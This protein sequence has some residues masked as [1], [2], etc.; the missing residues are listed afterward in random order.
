MAYLEE[1]QEA[2]G[3]T[4]INQHGQ[5]VK[6]SDFRG[7][8]V[9]LYFYPKDDTPGCTKEAC[10]LRDNDEVLKQKGFVV[11]GVSPDSEKSHEKFSDKFNLSFDLLADGNKEIIQA[12]GAWGPKNMYGR[13][14]EGVLRTTYVIDEQGNI[15][16][17]IKK[18][19]T[20]NHTHQILEAL[21][22][23]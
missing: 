12:Y 2:P 10:N 22:V 8:K 6:L 14:F 7:K 19:N 5:Q 13:M 21:G 18:V 16:K 3:F 15:E 20:G 9:V 11:L 4:G 23:E 1:G 17:V